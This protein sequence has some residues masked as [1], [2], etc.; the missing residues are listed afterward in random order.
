MQK[1]IR[2][3]FRYPK[4]PLTSKE[5]AKKRAKVKDTKGTLRRIWSYLAEKKGLLTLVM[6]MVV[7]SAIFGLLGPFVIGRAIDHFIVGR[8]T[9]GLLPV[10]F[11]LLGI[12]IVQSL[13]LWFQNYWMINISQSTVF[14]MR[15]ELFTHLHELPIPF[16]DKQRLGDLM[17]R[18]TNDIENVSSTLNTSVIQVLSSVIT[19][20]GTI[21]V[22]LYMSPLL[23]LITLLVIPIMF[24]SIKWITNRTGMLFKQQQKN[25]GELN[26]F[27]E[28]SISGAKV[29]KAYSREDRITEEFLEKNAAL[30]SSGFWAQTISGFIPKV[31]NSLNNLSFTIIA[32]IGGLFALKGW[33]SIGSIVVFAE[34]S[35][36]FTRPLNDL[37]NQF[38]TMLSAI[39]GA[40][41][42]FD[43]LD[44][45]E[46]R[47]DEEHALYQPITTG[48]IEFRDVSFGYEEGSPI[49]KHLS[50]K[51]PKGQSIAFVG[52]TGAGKTTV[53]SLIARFYE[54]N[55]GKV[56]IDGT[57]IKKLT[58]SSLRKNM[59]FVLQ[60]SFLFQGT[61][62]ENIR[63]GRL[64]ASDQEVEVAAKAANAHSFIERLPKGYD[65]VLTQN[66][67]GISQGQKQ[68]I[69]IA[70]AVLADPVLL[71]LDEA[72]SNIDTVTEVKIQEALGRL[73]EGRTSVIIA[74]RLNTIQ[75]ADQILVLKDGEMAEKGSHAE[76]LKQKGFYNE[77]YESQ[78]HE[79]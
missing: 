49:L 1:D 16:F 58:R 72:T 59:G 45:K 65:T 60:D 76:L 77:L 75:R 51:V 18:V 48:E 63:Y 66:G 13:S 7:I 2:K 28:E 42:V 32:A 78:F 14:K 8:T 70:R 62:R 22:M 79:S 26:G 54:P 47:Q 33:I 46:E 3:P 53:T 36:Q 4:I 37:A 41:R 40:E 30:K 52:P 23:T 19:F 73:M 71:I 44:E 17:S 35:R 55:E 67:A 5:G 21:A 12:Y 34:Y 29:I 24:I 64:D 61:I 27:I 50:F 10:L 43:V 38:N 56:L 25:L 57:D 20:V 69:S 11:I 31:M 39:A 68:L 9:N 15:S 6:V 74:H